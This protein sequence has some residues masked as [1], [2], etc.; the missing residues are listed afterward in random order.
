MASLT[1]ARFLGL[2]DETGA[3]APGL[4][5]DLVVVRAD[6]SVVSSWI[7]GEGVNSDGTNASAW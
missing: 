1:P 3:I 4:R 5:A 2:Q 7:G 6:F